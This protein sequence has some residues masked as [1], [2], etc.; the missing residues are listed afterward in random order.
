MRVRIIDPVTNDV[1][2][3]HGQADFYVNQKEGVAQ[4]VQTRMDLY[5]GD[6]TLDLT[7]GTSWR[8]QVLGKRTDATRDPAVRARI[9]GTTGVTGIASYASQ[10]DRQTRG[11]ASQVT[12]DTVYGQTIVAT[13]TNTPNGDVRSSR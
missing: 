13:P 11:F 12:I 5:V 7:A 10:L 3:G 1:R 6:W 9:L 8:T 2:F 4:N